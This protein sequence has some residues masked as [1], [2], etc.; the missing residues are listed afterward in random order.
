MIDQIHP[1][2]FVVKKNDKDIGSHDQVLLVV[3]S[4]QKQPE[5]K[6]PPG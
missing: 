3:F 2:R 5:A 1:P 6:L 4:A